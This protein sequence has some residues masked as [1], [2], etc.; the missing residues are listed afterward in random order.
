MNDLEKEKVLNEINAPEG[1]EVLLPEEEAIKKACKE[2]QDLADEFGKDI[3]EEFTNN[4][5]DDE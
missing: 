4:K 2:L 1:V 5:G 3:L